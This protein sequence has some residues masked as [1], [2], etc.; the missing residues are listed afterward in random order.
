VTLETASLGVAPTFR[1][2]FGAVFIFTA[3]A[4]AF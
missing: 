4:A 2:V 1:S 3:V